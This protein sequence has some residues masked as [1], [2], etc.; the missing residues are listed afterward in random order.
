[1]C[2]LYIE[3]VD[4]AWKVWTCGYIEPGKMEV[5]YLGVGV[6]GKHEHGE[7]EA[8]CS[9]QLCVCKLL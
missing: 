5:L 2:E 1:M 9:C 7:C 4:G 6:Q 8:R 3:S